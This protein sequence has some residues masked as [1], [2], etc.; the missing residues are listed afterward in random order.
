MAGRPSRTRCV[1]DWLR[2]TIPYAYNENDKI[3]DY[4]SKNNNLQTAYR[5]SETSAQDLIYAVINTLGLDG[6]NYMHFTGMMVRMLS[7]MPV[8]CIKSHFVL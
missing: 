7:V 5:V 4:L 8:L 1:L 2:I 6:V 3:T